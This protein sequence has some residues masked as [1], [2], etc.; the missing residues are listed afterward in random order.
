MIHKRQVVIDTV[1]CDKDTVTVTYTIKGVSDGTP[2]SIMAFAVEENATADVVWSGQNVAYQDIFA[3][4]GSEN[5]VT[6]QMPYK[7]VN[8]IAGIDTTRKLCIK[9]GGEYTD[10]DS[11]L[12]TIPP[13]NEPVITEVKMTTDSRVTVSLSRDIAENEVLFAAVY[14][15]GGRLIEVERDAVIPQGGGEYAVDIEAGEKARTVRIMWWTD[16]G[17]MQP[18]CDSKS[19]NISK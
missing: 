16:A 8:G 3:Y 1:H 5:S 10:T 15:I 19:V 11:K 9:L 2:I 6:F 12:L 14:D 7:T 4:S 18:L 17:G 13:Y